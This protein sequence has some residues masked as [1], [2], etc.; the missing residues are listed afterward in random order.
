MPFTFDIDT[1]DNICIITCQ[2]RLMDKAEA[3]ELTN[4]IDN[5]LIDG[6]KYFVVD[7]AKLDYISSSGLGFFI[8]L[9][10]R[11]RNHGGE[12]VLTEI[13]EKI[14]QLMLITKLNSVFTITEKRGDA[15]ARFTQPTQ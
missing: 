8:N 5:S 15:L 9:L 11:I 10:T 4:E 13:G 12:L 7:F 2:G 3:A 14:K 6:L 1:K